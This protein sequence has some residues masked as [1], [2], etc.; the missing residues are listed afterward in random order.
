MIKAAAWL[1]P[2]NRQTSAVTCTA[3]LTLAH[4]TQT[5]LLHM[6]TSLQSGLQAGYPNFLDVMV[7]S[8]NSFIKAG[9]VADT[10][11]VSKLASV[12]TSLSIMMAR[13]PRNSEIRDTYDFIPGNKLYETILPTRLPWRL[14]A[15][16]GFP[17]LHDILVQ[18]IIVRHLPPTEL[19]RQLTGLLKR[20]R[21]SRRRA[22]PFSLSKHGLDCLCDIQ[23][24]KIHTLPPVCCVPPAPTSQPGPHAITTPQGGCAVLCCVYPLLFAP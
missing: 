8:Y 24:S 14:A 13:Q 15:R 4:A 18:H 1:L 20:R 11:P 10:Q 16:A 2:H 21:A 19:Q 12:L 3:V 22:L 5:S 7:C 6:L 23:F 9:L 17:A